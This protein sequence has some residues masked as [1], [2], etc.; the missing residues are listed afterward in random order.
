MTNAE[1]KKIAKEKGIDV[2][3]KKRDEVIELLKNYI[4]EPVDDGDIPF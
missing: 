4:G 2:K 1:L 3:G